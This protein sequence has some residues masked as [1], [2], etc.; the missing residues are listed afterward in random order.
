MTAAFWAGVDIDEFPALKA[1]VVKQAVRPMT[2]E[3]AAAE[4]EAAGQTFRLYQ[5]KASQ[6]IHVIYRRGDETYGI[7]QPVKKA[8]R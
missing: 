5:D 3:E 8:G 7:V 1:A 2:P 4:M 6:Q